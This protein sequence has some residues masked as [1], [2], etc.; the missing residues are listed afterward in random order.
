MT[1][2]RQHYEQ[3]F[4]KGLEK[5][6]GYGQR[7][8][9]MKRN[10]FKK[11][12]RDKL[13]LSIGVLGLVLVTSI[14]VTTY[15]TRNAD[16]KDNLDGLNP[17]AQGSTEEQE[18][19]SRPSGIVADRATLE[20]E[21][22]GE[23][24]PSTSDDVANGETEPEETKP[25]EVLSNQVETLD[26]ADDTKIGWPVTG[27]VIQVFSMDTTVWFPTLEQYRVSPAIQIQGETGTGVACVADSKVLEVGKN[28]ELGN[29][30]V[31][32]MGNGYQATYGQLEDIRV[33]K[34]EYVTS[35]R[36]FAS[37]SEPS[38]YYVVDGPHLYFAMTKNE[39]PVD[40]LNYI[41]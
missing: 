38:K 6:S 25:V 1:K 40:P 29:Y 37:V 33:V 8:T 30:V 12:I 4:K 26:F 22:N 35:G 7:E 10:Y 18:S 27:N 14:V 20:D 24:I 39:T 34:G 5:A 3:S 28:E 17:V 31:M 21:N 23:N 2:N 32:D 16:N 11:L 36:V 9:E 41:Q 15:F 13:W 19:G